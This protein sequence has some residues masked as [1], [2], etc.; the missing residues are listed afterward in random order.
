MVCFILAF[1]WG[2]SV[3]SWSDSTII[4]TIVGF[5]AISAVFVANEIWMQERAVL[6]PR[7]M[8]MRRIWANNAHVF[9]VSGGFF[10]LIYYISIF[11]QSVQGRTPIQS[12]VRSLPI[13]IGCFLS[14]AS[15]MIVT[16]YGR[17]WAPLMT[18]GAILATIGA[19]LIHTWDLNT[20]IGEYIGYQVLTGVGTGITLQIPLMANQAAVTPMEISTISAVTIFFQIIGGAFSLA[21]AQAAFASTLVSKVTQ[22]APGIDAAN[23]LNVGASDL[24]LVY[25]GAEL[26]AVLRAYMD[27]IK[28]TFALATAL[29]GVSVLLALVPKWGE[30]RP[31]QA[32]MNTKDG[33]PNSSEDAV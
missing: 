6:V 29:L 33:E 9:C 26:D 28:V 31:Q 24:D 19:G 7:L 10:I 18:G 32:T 5:V 12:G 15:G 13:N 30:L 17:L 2:G 23:L 11:F 14:I 20:S 1:Q 22:Y 4:G 16:A 8:K 27:G 25:Q 21:A 3:K